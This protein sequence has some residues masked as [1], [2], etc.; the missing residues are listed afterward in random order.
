MTVPPDTTSNMS[1]AGFTPTTALIEA[2]QRTPEW[3]AQF[4]EAA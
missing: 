1:M 3:D 4:R 2:T